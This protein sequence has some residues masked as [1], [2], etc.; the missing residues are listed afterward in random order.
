[1]KYDL[2]EI[3][4]KL[5]TSPPQMTIAQV[6]IT[7]E[8]AAAF[9]TSLQSGS[10]TDLL[11]GAAPAPAPTAGT[12]GPSASSGGLGGSAGDFEQL[13]GNLSS[14]EM[15]A[16]FNRIQ[17]IKWSFQLSYDPQTSRESELLDRLEKLEKKIV[18]YSNTSTPMPDE[19]KTLFSRELQL[20]SDMI[21]G[22]TTKTTSQP[23]RTNRTRSP[24]RATSGRTPSGYNRTDNRVYDSFDRGTGTRNSSGSY[25]D[26]D[27]DNVL[28]T[29]PH[30]SADVRIR[31]GFA[32]TDEQIRRR[33]SSAAFLPQRAGGADY[34]QRVRDLCSQIRGAGIGE[35]AVFGCI[36][37]PSEVSQNYSWK[38]NYNMICS[39]L[40][41]TWGSWYPEMFGCPKTSPGDK[42]NGS[43][44]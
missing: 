17:D 36:E 37:N 1:L 22:T 35:P 29:S 21:R 6:G 38:G 12:M 7:K 14:E 25:Y 28:W 16:I 44:L 24:P 41:D 34:K 23:G 11:G 4:R 42:Y 9:L 32:M 2:S 15:Q 39:R 18:A 5:K 31:P 33:G 20:I 26:D 3:I 27:N 13:L 40:G 10:Y 8:S 43:M 30:T 19:L